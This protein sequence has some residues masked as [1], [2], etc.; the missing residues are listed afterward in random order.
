MII[1]IT[2]KIGSG[3]T[4]LASYLAN[5]G[6]KDGQTII[7]N[8]RL[9]IPHQLITLPDIEDYANKHSSLKKC[10]LILDEAQTILD[11]RQSIKNRIMSYFILQTRK[12]DVDIVFTSQQFWNVEKRLRENTDYVLVCSAIRSKENNKILLAVNV[13][14]NEYEGRD[15]FNYRGNFMIR[16][17]ASVFKLYDTYE[18]VDFSEKKNNKK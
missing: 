16:D 11:C 3:K 4:L 8:Y 7:S 15:T 10:M 6:H 13:E 12:R 2:G 5:E 18:I 14:I 17:P 9:K 1:G